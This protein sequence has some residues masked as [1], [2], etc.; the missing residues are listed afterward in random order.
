M[1]T[2][3]I[4]F[5]PQ[6][7]KFGRGRRGFS[8]TRLAKKAG[9]SLRAIQGFE[10]GE[11]TPETES[12][13]R[14]ANALE[15]PVEF[16]F[17]ED[18][19]TLSPEGVSFRSMAKMTSTQAR[20]ALGAGGLALS[21][22]DWIERQF[23]LP[24]PNV[25]SLSGDTTPETAADWLRQEWIL[26][27]L[28]I[29]NMVHLL[30]AR[31]VRVYSLAID[32][33]EVD[34]F[35]FW[36]GDTPFI[37][38]NTGKSAER[39]RYDAAHELGHL[40]MHKHASPNGQH[41]EVEAN[42]FASAFLMPRNSILAHPPMLATVDVLMRLKKVWNVSMMAL[43]R[44]LHDLKVLTDWHYHVLCRQM[45]KEGYR[46]KEPEGSQRETSQVLAKV[47]AALREGGTT[48]ADI[49]SELCVSP[50]EIDELVFGLALTGLPG[51]SKRPRAPG[52]KTPHLKLV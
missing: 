21:L 27:D 43:A 9:F 40:V 51:S 41:A 45:S 38:L 36:R 17:G 32:A 42:A 1:T 6:R 24:P 18:I 29:R 12:V 4:A 20:V 48:K 23:A 34:A 2:I 52:D 8:Q 35:S 46:T 10:G 15:F 37:F 3:E 16:F 22:N 25:P 26:G 47:L 28:P 30:E 13:G 50:S 11:I 5:N 31:G 44:R 19:E 39:S 14:L 49:A 7:L 33:R